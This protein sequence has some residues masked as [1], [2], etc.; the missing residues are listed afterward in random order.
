MRR[1]LN[2]LL[3]LALGLAARAAVL[4]LWPGLSAADDEAPQTLRHAVNGRFLIGT[5]VMSRQ[6][7][8]SAMAELVARQFNSVTSENEFKPQSL[9]PQAGKFRF[10][11]ADKIVDFAQHHD[12]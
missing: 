3:P 9:Q 12:M 1:L 5:A 11:A 2:S 10:D 7:D 6:L 4:A 8:N